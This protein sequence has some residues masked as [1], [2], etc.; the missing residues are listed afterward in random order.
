[1]SLRSV[2]V[3]FL[4][5]AGPA[6][7]SAAVYNV[8]SEVDNPEDS[9]GDGVCNPQFALQPD[10][11]TLRAAIQDANA[12]PGLDIIFV[13]PGTYALTRVGGDDDALN[14]DLDI[15]EA[16]QIQALDP[17]V[18]RPMIDA[19]AI[20]NRAFHILSGGVSLIG[21][22]VTS[23]SG[24]DA[25][26][27]ILVQAPGATNIVLNL[28]RVHR[29]RADVGSG[30]YNAGADVSVDGSSF[31][32]NRSPGV[33]GSNTAGSAIF[34]T[35]TLRLDQSSVFYNFGFTDD[36]VLPTHAILSSGDLDLVNSVV[37][38]N[39]GNGITNTAGGFLRLDNATIA[40]NLFLGV[41]YD[42][43]GE[44]RMGNSAVAKNGL[45]DCLLDAEDP[46]LDL[47]RYNLD[48]DGTCALSGGNTNFAG[49][50]PR[51]TPLA[52][53]GGLVVVSWP[54]TSS[55]LLEAGHPADTP[56]GCEDVDQ[57]NR[58]RPQDFDG[59]GIARCDIGAIELSDDLIFFD[60][61]EQM[62]PFFPSLL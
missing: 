21:L 12:H 52:S 10:L 15:T 59:N 36:E 53:R 54:L 11:C 2:F 26:G 46:G 29:N 41:R 56:L 58:P 1:M 57:Q 34:S 14:G 60:P 55:P 43:D 13:Q 6:P 42:G 22:D 47:N 17:I 32:Y 49:V 31:F 16:V 28:L 8:N 62:G 27:G 4:F 18:Q 39:Y 35:G 24:V 44:L 7:A 45:R 38:N 50:E 5:A 48:S 61:V 33:D 19:G 9:P 20:D 30:L 51:L 40:G 3:S 37:A 23:G 25:G